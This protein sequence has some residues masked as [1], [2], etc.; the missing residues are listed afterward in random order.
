M[1]KRA[2]AVALLLSLM[3]CAAQDSPRIS[4][5]RRDACALSY[6]PG[7]AGLALCLRGIYEP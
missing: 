1:R 4:A 5:E 6:G 7:T 2:L 3:G